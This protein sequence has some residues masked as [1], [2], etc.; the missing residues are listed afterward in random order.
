MPFVK[1]GESNREVGGS[2]TADLHS[3]PM[4]GPDANPPRERR[5]S[6]VWF[7]LRWKNAMH[8]QNGSVNSSEGAVKPHSPTL[9]SDRHKRWSLAS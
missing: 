8:A 6:Q 9:K 2:A 5:G 1:S 3:A 4:W 7:I